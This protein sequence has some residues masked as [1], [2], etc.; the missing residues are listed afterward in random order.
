MAKPKERE[1]ANLVEG[2]RVKSNSSGDLPFKFFA[3]I[4]IDN[5]RLWSLFKKLLDTFPAKVGLIYGHI[6]DEE[7]TYSTYTDKEE[8]IR[9]LE[10]HERELTQD[11]YFEFGI[12][13]HDDDTLIETFVKKGKYIQYWG[14][15]YPAFEKI[16]EE[17][18]LGYVA[19]LNFID[20]FP[21]STEALIDAL[22]TDELIEYLKSEF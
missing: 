7:L 19:D 5:D 1:T 16:M 17:C 14:M 11:G 18:S 6:D 20:E 12:T 8:L 15:D 13:Y 2:Y 10:K 9:K 21:L 22:S 4:N 3:E